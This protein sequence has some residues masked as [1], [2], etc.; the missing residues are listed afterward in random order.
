MFL[1]IYLIKRVRAGSRRVPAISLYS[2]AFA[3]NMMVSIEK[4]NA[5]MQPENQSK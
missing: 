4:M 3:M 1:K 5:C 2:L